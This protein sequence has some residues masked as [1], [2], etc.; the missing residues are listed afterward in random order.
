M[1]HVGQKAA[2]G[3]IGRLRV[4]QGPLQGGILLSQPFQL[5]R[6]VRVRLSQLFQLAGVC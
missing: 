1:G 4:R 3:L 5:P 2:F 6:Q